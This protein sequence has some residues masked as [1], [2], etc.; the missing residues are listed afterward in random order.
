MAKG[1]T[2]IMGIDT[3]FLRPPEVINLLL[4]KYKEDNEVEVVISPK[5]KDMEKVD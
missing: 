5:S 3:D 2:I 4:N 1:N